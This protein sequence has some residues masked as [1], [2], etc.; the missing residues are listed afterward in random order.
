M[1]DERQVEEVLARYVRAVDWRDGPSLAALF[2]DDAHV[3]IFYGTGKDS[4]KLGELRGAQTIGAAVAGAMAPHPPRGW[5]HHTTSNPIVEVCGDQATL[6]VQFIV[7]NVVGRE[8]PS[9]GWPA[10][11]L[12]AQGT[13][14][15]IES[16]YYRSTMRRIDGGWKI[17]EHR[18]RHD[19]PYAFPGA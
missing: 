2:E 14:T 15:P 18:I 3:E 11:S 12:G 4:E 10:G 13:I 6:D 7:S 9:A 1:D 16:G 19:M 8:R 5:S 17:S